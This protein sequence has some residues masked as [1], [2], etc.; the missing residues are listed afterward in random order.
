MHEEDIVECLAAEIVRTRQE[1]YDV[2]VIASQMEREINELPTFGTLVD[3]F[4]VEHKRNAL[5]RGILVM[6]AVER[7][8][9]YECDVLLH[10]LRDCL[11]SIQFE[12]MIGR[13][14]INVY[15]VNGGVSSVEVRVP[16]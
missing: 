1:R 6:S 4:E 14:R 11:P 10:Q 5:R 9:D 8:L 16:R 15:A 3:M 13:Y 7:Q 12:L 2:R